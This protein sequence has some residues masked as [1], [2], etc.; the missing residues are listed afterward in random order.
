MNTHTNEQLLMCEKEDLVKYITELKEQVEEIDELKKEWVIHKNEAHI[1]NE[2]MMAHITKLL[3]QDVKEDF[4][5]QITIHA[6]WFSDWMKPS[7]YKH[8]DKLLVEMTT[9]SSSGHGCYENGYWYCDGGL[10]RYELQ[11]SGSGT[12]CYN[13]IETSEEE[14]ED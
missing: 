13:L 12:V 14:D 3:E 4:D 2:F 8:I 11:H 10:E 6:S 1:G 9:Y 5:G 7:F